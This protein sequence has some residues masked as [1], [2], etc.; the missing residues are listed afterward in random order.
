MKNLLL[1]LF[2][3][4]P[5]VAKSQVWVNKG[6]VWH[7]QWSGVS[8]G[9]FHKIEYEKDTMIAGK[10]CNKLTPLDYRFTTNE[11]HEI[12]P[13]G[14]FKMKSQYTYVNGDTVFYLVNNKFY[15]LYNFG[16]KP[17]D[18]WNIGVDTNAYKCSKSFV[19]VD[20]IGTI[21]INS[22]A[23][24][25]ISL[26]TLPNSSMGLR[27][28][29]IERYGAAEDYLF[30]TERNC[31]TNMV[32]D[33]TAYT[34]SCFQDENFPLYNVLNKDCE[35]LLKLGVEEKKAV[36]EVY[37]IPT[38]DI[39]HFRNFGDNIW[40]IRIYTISGWEVYAQKTKLTELD[41][42]DSKDGVYFLKAADSAGNVILKK[43]IKIK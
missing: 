34:F 43:V 36:V 38:R 18:T 25:W 7:Y 24:R 11:K 9:G 10:L 12:V 31:N 28:K 14:N 2:L 37:P 22:K 26:S 19:K 23:Y 16:A 13:L 8:F 39:L 21:N 6:A 4:F 15:V 17:G 42:S 3:T 40:D 27:G 30:P 1:I 20:S 33:F 41:L 32:V 29:I 5:F 35:Y